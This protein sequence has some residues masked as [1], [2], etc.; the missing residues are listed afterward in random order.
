MG[1]LVDRFEEHDGMRRVVA[2][3]PRRV[4][5]IIKVLYELSPSTPAEH[6]WLRVEMTIKLK[7]G[8]SSVFVA[9]RTMLYIAI[10]DIRPQSRRCLFT[11]HGHLDYVR[12]VQFHHEMPW[13]VRV[14][15][16]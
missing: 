13:I 16:Q 4:L 11:L 12:T 5:T 15:S 6:S 10:A 9:R 2:T 7:C 3:C 14:L 8:V 1:V